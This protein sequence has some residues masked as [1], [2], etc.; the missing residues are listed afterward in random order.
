MISYI[1]QK[2]GKMSYC[3]DSLTATVFDGLKYL[4]VELFWKILKN[5]LYS[6]YERLPHASGEI[7]SFSFWGKWSV[8]DFRT[9]KESNKDKITNKN[10]VEPD[11]FIRFHDFDIIIEAK[12]Y[13]TKQQKEEQQRNE[14]LAY[15]NEYGEEKQLYFIQ[16]GGLQNKDDECFKNVVI[17]KTDWSSLMYSISKVKKQLEEQANTSIDKAV[18]RILT[19]ILLGLELHQFYNIKWLCTFKIENRLN[20][21]DINQLLTITNN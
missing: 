16:C 12:R 17:C 13:D 21:L 5:S 6:D 19:D 9:K 4:P 2:K 8:K 14:I 20:D 10:F 15:F 1:S 3:E 7:E 11:L 18:C